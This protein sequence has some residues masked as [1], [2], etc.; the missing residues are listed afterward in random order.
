M[1]Y[2]NYSI[3]Y[4]TEYNDLAIYENSYSQKKKNS[5]ILPICTALSGGVLGATAGLLKNPYMTKNTVSDSFAKNVYENYLNLSS[6]SLKNSYNESKDI[7]KNINKIKDKDELKNLLNNNPHASKEIYVAINQTPEEFL[8]SI[9]NS[10]LSKNKDVIKEKLETTN[11]LRIQDAKNKIANC[12]NKNAKKF[13]NK[14]DIDEKFFNAIES[15]KKKITTKQILIYAG[16]ASAIGCLIGLIVNKI[17]S[18]K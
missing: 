17:S 12:W 4:G 3:P 2:S 6:D 13:E 5:A 7:I 10:N 9:D 1:T 18:N 15:T 11:N 16:I 8:K 14:L